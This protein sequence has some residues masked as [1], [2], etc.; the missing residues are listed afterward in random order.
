M[1]E[2]D[3]LDPKFIREQIDA[4]DGRMRDER[5]DWQVYKAAYLTRF[6]KA[7]Q[8]QSYH[9]VQESPAQIQ[10]EVNRLYGIIESYVSALYPKASRVVVG[11]GPT[12]GGDPR[13]AELVANKWLL[14]NRTHLRVLKAIRQ[15][16]IYPGAGV[17][18]GVDDTAVD[19]I[20]RVWFRVIPWWE[21]LLDCDV[22]DE[23]DARFI[24][25]IYYRPVEEVEEQ[26]GL[27][28]L[29]GSPRED[30]LDGSDSLL[31][32]NPRKDK[33]NG[34]K[35]GSHGD[36]SAFVRVLELCNFVDSFQGPNGEMRGRMEVYLLDQGKEY[37]DPVWIGPMP[38][39]SR[40]GDPIPHIA[41]LIFNEEPEYP[42]RGVSQA[43]RVYPQI[44]EINIFRS[45]RA[46][47]ARRDS[48]QYVCLDGV[49][50]A[51]QMSQITAGVDGLVIPV[52]ETRLQGRSL[53]DIMVPIRSNPISQNIDNYEALA[54]ADLQR[55]SG[56]SPNAYG[57]VT[58]ATATEVMN[59]R[60]YT[61]SEFGRHAMIKDGWIAQLVRMFFRALIAAME[62]PDAGGGIEEQNQ[63]LNGKDEELAPQQAMD[64]MEKV[65]DEAV[66]DA[67]EVIEE[68]EEQVE[69]QGGEVVG[70]VAEVE[71][72]ASIQPDLVR[73]KDGL[74][75]LEITI[76]DLDG[77]FAV[78]V[79]DSR[80]TPFSESAVRQAMIT[81]LEPLQMLWE[82]VSK[83][84][85]SAKLARAQMVALVEKF[86]L[87]GDMHPDALEAALESEAEEAE[88]AK[89]EGEGQPPSPQEQA[90]PPGGPPPGMMPEE[91]AMPPGMPVQGGPPPGGP[92][93]PAPPP[94]SQ[95]MAPMA[96]PTAAGP[97]PGPGGALPALPIS[98]ELAQ[99]ILS[100]PPQQA[101]ETIL[102][103]LMEMGAPPEIIQ[104][105]QEALNY[106]PEQQVQFL[107][108]LLGQAGAVG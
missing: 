31:H 35:K 33:K 24:G 38:F 13:K 101:L 65:A 11:P 92:P 77:D 32:K 20:D 18:L 83:G 100:L 94:A 59:L 64:E 84:G 88:A 22:Y 79:V 73:I 37:E 95:A 76:E 72:K 60:D 96:P 67:E 102:A 90:M 51:D 15:A 107:Q 34:Q 54:D 53:N 74:E 98:P 6:W 21:L 47:A 17:K 63:V 14:Q 41:P 55:A 10:I 86:D 62:A 89:A 104:L 57:A 69:E 1:A 9:S 81:L 2:N 97:P 23:E 78:E 3:I 80:R 91:A 52:E 50:T 99:Q 87:P 49:L 70:A 4:H 68:V 103:A 105:V 58:Q 25:H 16:L 26:Y 30:F 56:T 29:K 108:E 36:E 82:I 46:N 42:L 75:I 45:F 85:P 19:P 106:P 43:S 12:L 61:E 27:R 5:R 28:E 8:T 66:E 39:S 93:P 44:S 48:R 71:V 40:D 7:H